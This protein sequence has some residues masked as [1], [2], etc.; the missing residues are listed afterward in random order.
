[1]H[2]HE[3][4][5]FI[6]GWVVAQGCFVFSPAHFTAAIYRMAAAMKRSVPQSCALAMCKASVART[7]LDSRTWI[8]DPMTEDVNWMIT[9]ARK[10]S[11]RYCLVW[12]YWIT[13]P[14]GILRL[15]PLPWHD[16][17][18][19]FRAQHVPCPAK[20]QLGKPARK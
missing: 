20:F 10:S 19:I 9:G 11:G 6:G 1:M 18:D 12:R 4:M 14:D 2:S 13:L 16:G 8:A 5:P 15:R 7:E 17:N 3:I